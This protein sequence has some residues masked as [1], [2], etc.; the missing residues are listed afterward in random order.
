MKVKLIYFKPSGKFYADGGYDTTLTNLWDIWGEVEEMLLRGLLP[1]MVE[2]AR[3]F[4]MYVEVPEHPHNHPH[5]II[6][7]ELYT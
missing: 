2:G 5:L 3:E 1:D 7:Q 6:K 4:I